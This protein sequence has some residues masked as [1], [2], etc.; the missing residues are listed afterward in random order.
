MWRLLSYTSTCETT[1]SLWTSVQ[2][3]GSLTGA[4]ACPAI[5]PH[6][7]FGC[8]RFKIMNNSDISGSVL[9]FTDAGFDEAIKGAGVPDVVLVDFWAAWCRPC[10]TL[11]PIMERVAESYAG[12]VRVGKLDADRN[13]ETLTRFG[14]RSLPTVLVFKAGELVGQQVGAQPYALYARYLDRLLSGD[15]VESD[16][17]FALTSA[18]PQPDA[19]SEV[20]D[21]ARAQAEALKAEPGMHVIFKHSNTCPF[22]ASGK[23][24]YDRFMAL[25]PS[26]PSRLVIVQNERALS[27]ALEEVLGVKHESPQAILLEN[28]EVRWHAS[29]GKITVDSL[30]KAIGEVEV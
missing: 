20:A 13:P 5:Q 6:P 9:E 24:Q 23:R 12:R 29:H 4:V 3:C 10:L 8:T 15:T 27:N 22:S 19:G 2:L 14:V 1:G 26:L 16:A 18:R 7:L 17:D 11:A 21:A 30:E 28:G 25:H